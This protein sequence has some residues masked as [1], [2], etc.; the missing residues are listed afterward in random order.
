MLRV[1]KA[2]KISLQNQLFF[3]NRKGEYRIKYVFIS[4]LAR[5][6]K[7]SSIHFQ[8]IDDQA[9]E[10]LDFLHAL[11]AVPENISGD[12]NFFTPSN[13]LLEE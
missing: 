13:N 3:N 12:E 7:I 10:L 4:K 9:K 2:G 8:E 1:G 6:V 5:N 11:P